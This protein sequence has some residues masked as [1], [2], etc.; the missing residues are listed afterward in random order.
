MAD[1]THS[2]TSQFWADSAFEVAIAGQ[3]G[4]KVLKLA[5]REPFDLTYPELKKIQL[6][7]V[8]A[9]QVQVRTLNNAHKTMTFIAQGVE[10]FHV[11]ISDSS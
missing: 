7:A 11:F 10:M 9:T 3:S 4:F 1:S 2:K 8:N 6:E 5:K